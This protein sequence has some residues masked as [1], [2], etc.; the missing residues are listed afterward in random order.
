MLTEERHSIILQELKS[1]SVVYVN[2]LVKKLNSS[3]STIR[4][5]LNTLHKQGKLNKVHGGAISLDRDINTTEDDV[6]VRQALNIGEK[7]EI[8]KYAASLIEPYDFVYI[9]AGTTTEF[10]IDFIKEKQATFI[11]NGINQAKKLIKNGC[12]TYIL[13]G[14]VK[15]ITEAMIGVEAVNSLEKYNFTKGFFGTNGISEER[16]Y[17]TPDIR[18]ALVKEKALKRSKDAYILADNSKFNKISSVIFGGIQKATIIT[19]KIL[20]NKYKGLTN[21]VEVMK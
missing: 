4:R 17:T 15:G 1:N 19:T 20:D 7:L 16:G 3:E 11:T 14:E 21:I 10:M 6:C 8:G 12:K 5:D 2:D 9:D 13:G 18:E